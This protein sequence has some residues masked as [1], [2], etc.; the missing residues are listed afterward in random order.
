MS[1]LRREAMMRILKDR[2]IKR[3]IDL[4]LGL[5]VELIQKLDTRFQLHPHPPP[6]TPPPPKL[7]S[8]EK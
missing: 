7:A 4:A 8:R 1:E 2:W 3:F 5:A 6:P